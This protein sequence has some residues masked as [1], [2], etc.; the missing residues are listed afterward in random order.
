M[1]WNILDNPAA[2]F[3]VTTVDQ[4]LDVPVDKHDFR[5]KE[6]QIVYEMYTSPEVFKDA[7]VT[8]Q[9]VGMKLEEEAV[10]GMTEI[11]SKIVAGYAK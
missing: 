9:L 3:P 1:L 6:D 2:I 5:C 11:V 10:I 8:L 4:K 7:P